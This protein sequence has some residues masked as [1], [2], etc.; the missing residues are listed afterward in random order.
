MPQYTETQFVSSLVWPAFK[1]AETMDEIEDRYG[2][3]WELAEEWLV[4][5]E[6]TDRQAAIERMLDGQL[7]RWETFKETGKDPWGKSAEG[8]GGMVATGSVIAGGLA[9]A[10]RLWTGKWFWSSWV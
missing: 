8:W 6:G 9:L 4:V 10:H 1:R 7:A 5:P 3:A 2:E